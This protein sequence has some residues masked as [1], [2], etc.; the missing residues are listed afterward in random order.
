MGI[1]NSRILRPDVLELGGPQFPHA[2]GISLRLFAAYQSKWIE[3]EI[4]V[5][6]C[7]V[8]LFLSICL[9]CS[10][11]DFAECTVTSIYIFEICEILAIGERDAQALP[12]VCE[13]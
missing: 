6:V 11:G 8:C 3:D 9:S 10:L 4:A 7:S 5:Q 12:L 2:A 13:I 1:G